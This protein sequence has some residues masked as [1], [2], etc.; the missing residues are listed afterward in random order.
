MMLALLVTAG[1]AVTFYRSASTAVVLLVQPVEKEPGTIS[2]P[3][4]SPEGEQRA[5]QLVRMFADPGGG[6]RLEA[7]YV[8]DDRRAAQTAATL[9]QRLQRTPVVFRASDARATASRVLREHPGGT[10]L[11]VASGATLAEMVLELSGV[12]IG[13]APGGESDALYVVSVPT[14]GRAHLVQLR[15]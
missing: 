2:D 14:F 6:G 8:S 13:S 9:A 12:S 3:P 1:V 5:Q 7:I 10:V 4:L 15:F 11:V